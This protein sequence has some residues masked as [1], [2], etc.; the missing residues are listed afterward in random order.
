MTDPAGYGLDEFLGLAARVGAEATLVSPWND[1]PPEEV[2]ALVAYV[3]AET[4]SAITISDDLSNTTWGTGGDWARRRADNGHPAP[5]RVPF[6]EIGNEQ[7]LIIPTPPD[8]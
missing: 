5:Y 8:D 4:S 1:A 6:L 3:N 7:Y 2:A